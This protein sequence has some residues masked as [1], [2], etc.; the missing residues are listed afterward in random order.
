M[1][2]RL[3]TSYL[4]LG[5]SYYHE[6]TSIYFP[7]FSNIFNHVN[8]GTDV[9]NAPKTKT[10]KTTVGAAVQVYEVWQSCQAVFSSRSVKQCYISCLNERVTTV[11]TDLEKCN[12]LAL[13]I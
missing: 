3:L 13:F 10:N 8:G 7:S 4:S 2:V 5:H 12:K 6:L 1:G 11:T 9:Q